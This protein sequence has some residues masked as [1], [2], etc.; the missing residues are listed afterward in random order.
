MGKRLAT[1]GLGVFLLADIVLVALALRPPS[2]DADVGAGPPSTVRPSST[3]PGTTATSTGPVTPTPSESASTSAAPKPSAPLPVQRMVVGL[4][5][6]N[7]W[8]ATMGSCESGGSLVQVTDDGGRTWSKGTSPA[9]AL[10]RIAPQLN[11]VGLVYAAG[12]DCTLQE[13]VTRDDGATWT[14]PTPAN[15]A[16]TRLL[17]DVTEVSTPSDA[18]ATPCGTAAVLDLSRT[19]P[20]QAEALCANGKVVVTDDGG[21]SWADSGSAPGAMA[22]S[23]RLEAGVLTS[24]AAR[25]S[26][27]CAGV[28]IVRVVQGRAASPVACVETDAAP[29]PGQ[30]GISAAPAA[31]WLVVGKQTWTSGADLRT[32]KP[33]A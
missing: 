2:V 21:T 10:A 12:A 3:A 1:I 32:W 27:S 7:A 31:G 16:W 5:A 24:Y 33:S 4:D 11:G 30:V 25:L 13:W 26:S 29:E 14:G 18:N 22:L 8:R 20:E 28:Q 23:N 9:K 17:S 19:T 15:N 6:N